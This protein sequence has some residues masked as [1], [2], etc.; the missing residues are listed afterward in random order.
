MP[1]PVTFVRATL[2]DSDT[3]NA[4]AFN[5]LTAPSATVPDATPGTAGVMPA[6][7]TLAGLALINALDAAAQRAAL[8]LGSLALQAANTVAIIGGAINGTPIGGTTPSTVAAT[9]LGLGNFSVA[10]ASTSVL[11][12]TGNQ[13]SNALQGYDGTNAYGITLFNA[14]TP[15]VVLQS[16]GASSFAL[17]INNTNIGSGGVGTGAFST[18]SATGAIRVM[19][20]NVY[21]AGTTSGGANQI[22][23]GIGADDNTAILSKA[24]NTIKMDAGG[25]TVGT[26]SAAGLALIGALSSTTGANFATSSGAVGIGTTSIESGFKLHVTGNGFFSQPSGTIG[27]VVIDTADNRLVLGSYFEAGV[28]QFS[29]IS[30]TNNAETGDVDL[31]LRT[32]TTERARISAI[33]FSVT[34]SSTSTGVSLVNSAVGTSYSYKGL[35]ATGPQFFGYDDVVGNAYGG[36]VRGYSVAAQGGYVAL[37]TVQNNTWVSGL[38]I[39]HLNNVATPGNISLATGTAKQIWAGGTANFSNARFEVTYDSGVANPTINGQLF[40]NLATS[41][42]ANAMLFFQNNVQVGSITTTNTATAYITS[43]DRRLKTNIRDYT[44]SGKVVDAMRPRQF[45][46]QTGERDSIGFVAQELY[47]VAPQ[48]VRAG[49]ADPATITQQWGV[50]FSKLVP[51]LVAEVKCLRARVAQLEAA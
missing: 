9:A 2:T 18:L 37:G 41:G 24:G 27:K 21:Y 7:T 8:G 36:G 16:N 20:N 51:V 46:W 38:T 15:S 35:H 28:G 25:S 5:A 31:V 44:A 48:A 32:G 6:T 34:G 13:P 45:D 49:D 1:A 11:R 23:I 50:D 40:R 22:L 10:P 26:F 19:T 47:E 43:S 17:G 33:G 3:L 14:A 39:D 29:F 42:T 12:F 30:S 4:A